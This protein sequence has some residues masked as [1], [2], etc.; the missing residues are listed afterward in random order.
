MA[1]T[2][3]P[4]YNAIHSKERL[5]LGDKVRIKPDIKVKQYGKDTGLRQE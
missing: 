1:F 2:F 4:T 3:C 5:N